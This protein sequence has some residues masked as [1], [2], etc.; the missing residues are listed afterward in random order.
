MRRCLTTVTAWGDD[1]FATDHVLE[2]S[3]EN[4][5]WLHLET[6]ATKWE[7]SPDGICSCWLSQIGSLSVACTGQQWVLGNG[8]CFVEAFHGLF[9]L[10]PVNVGFSSYTLCYRPKRAHSERY[11]KKPTGQ[12]RFGYVPPTNEINRSQWVHVFEKPRA[13]S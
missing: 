1:L 8:D 3:L 7:P 13:P 4:L 6:N 10:S 9:E 5:L 12:A 2:E 11:K